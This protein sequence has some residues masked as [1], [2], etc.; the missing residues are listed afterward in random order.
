M[1]IKRVLEEGLYSQTPYLSTYAVV[2]KIMIAEN[3]R[4]QGFFIVHVARNK[5]LRKKE[6][7]HFGCSLE[8]IQISISDS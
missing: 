3:C 8:T 2:P 1:F 5:N 4:H 6:T 7:A